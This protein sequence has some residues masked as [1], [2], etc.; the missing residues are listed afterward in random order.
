MY[1]QVTKIGTRGTM[2]ISPF[3][4]K[5]END[6]QKLM[7]ERKAAAEEY[8]RAREEKKNIKTEEATG[9]EK[10]VMEF[11]METEEKETNR[12]VHFFWF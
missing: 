9:R 5:K 3:V 8:T 11:L 2:Q 7:N 10:E 6:R 1:D 12:Q 4:D